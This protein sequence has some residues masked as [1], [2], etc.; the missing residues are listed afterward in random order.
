MIKF[1]AKAVSKKTK[2][3]MEWSLHSS[4]KHTLWSSDIE[5]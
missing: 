4:S 5:N 1:Q 2:V 3:K